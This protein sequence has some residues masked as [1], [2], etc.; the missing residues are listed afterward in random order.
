[1]ALTRV[2]PGSSALAL[3]KEGK[4]NIMKKLVVSTMALGFLLSTGAIAQN[5][6][7]TMSSTTSKHKKHKKGKST[8]TSSTTSS[9][10]TTK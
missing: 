10:T 3:L 8:D 4:L 7:S 6:S 2:I 5:T 9:T 1:M